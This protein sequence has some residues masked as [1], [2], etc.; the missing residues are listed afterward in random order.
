M[1]R[2]FSLL[3]EY[4]SLVKD[5]RIFHGVEDGAREI[6]KQE[7]YELHFVKYVA[8][9]QLSEVRGDIQA[10]FRVVELIAKKAGITS[11]EI[12]A[13]CASPPSTDDDEN[14]TDDK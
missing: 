2:V 10:L 5:V 7:A 9:P 1:V 6:S 13:A 3:E 11:A 8:Q 14:E 12:D 4:P